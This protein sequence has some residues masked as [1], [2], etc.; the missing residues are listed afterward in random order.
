MKLCTV[1][2]VISE[3]AGDYFQFSPGRRAGIPWR[4]DSVYV[5]LAVFGLIAPP[6]RHS[7]RWF[8]ANGVTPLDAAAASQLADALQAYAATLPDTDAAALA[9]SLGDWLRAHGAAGITIERL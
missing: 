5:P 4:H 8:H 9:A 3:P 6:V 1:E 2:Q 7:V